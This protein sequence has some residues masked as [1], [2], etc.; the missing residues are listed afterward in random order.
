MREC[1]VRLD[2][3][4]HKGKTDKKTICH[5]IWTISISGRQASFQSCRGKGK[6]SI[7]RKPDEGIQERK[8]NF[9]NIR[10]KGNIIKK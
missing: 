3:P 8:M 9:Q 10:L 6:A 1:L 5:N 2:T 4:Q 7:K